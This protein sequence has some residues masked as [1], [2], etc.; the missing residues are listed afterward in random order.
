MQDIRDALKPAI[1]NSG[2]KHISVAQKMG[3]N[4]QQLS[5][6][7]NKRRKLDA[8]EMIAFCK[9]VG[10]TPNELYLSIS[11]DQKPA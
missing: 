3:L 2:L 8:N 4:E 7:I 5:D 6:I 10:I 9:I 1:K 11:N